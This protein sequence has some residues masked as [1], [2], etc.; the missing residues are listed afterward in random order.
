M[1]NEELLARIDQK[2]ADHMEQYKSDREHT[3][4]WRNGF[5]E[6]LQKID[7][8]LAPIERDHYFVLRLAKWCGGGLAL[9]ATTIGVVASLVKIVEAIR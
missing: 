9:I 5:I 7:N 6:R 2:L 3:G 4:R 1:D 8:R